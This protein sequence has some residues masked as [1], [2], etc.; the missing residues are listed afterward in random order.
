MSKQKEILTSPRTLVLL[1]EEGFEPAEAAALAARLGLPL[2]HSREEAGSALL[3]RAGAD[4]LALESEGQTMRCD[5]ARMLPRLR[6]KNL[7]GELLVHAARIRGLDRAPTAVDATAGL[8]EDSL[9]LAAAGFSVRMYE[10]NPVIAALLK[11]ALRRAAETPQ[12][13]EIISRMELVEADSLTE[14]P[15]L[16]QIPDLIFLDP[17]FPTRE[18]SALVKKKFQLL[19]CLELPCAQEEA[20]LQAAFLASP[21]KIVVKRPPKGPYLGGRKPNYSLTGKAVR[22]DC[23]VLPGENGGSPFV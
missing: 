6:Q 21:R 14:M 2:V 20:L 19:H 3:L 1:A 8:G 9:L 12:L 4:G 16:A 23:F 18:K 10:R 22:Y 5:L 7:S 15:R 11:D 17:M 13:C